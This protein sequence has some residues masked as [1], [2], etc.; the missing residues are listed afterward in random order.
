MNDAFSGLLE[1]FTFKSFWLE[2]LDYDGTNFVRMMQPWHDHVYNQKTIAIQFFALLLALIGLLLGAVKNRSLALVTLLIILT[3]VVFLVGSLPIPLFSQIFRS[4]FTKWSLP[5]ALGVSLCVA[6]LFLTLSFIRGR[7]GNLVSYSTLVAVIVIN[8]LIV[9]PVFNGKLIYEALSVSVPERYY[10]MFRKIN[11]LPEGTR[12]VSF[13][14]YSHWGWSFKDWGYRGSSLLTYG[15]KHSLMDRTFDVW[16]KTGEEYYDRISKSLY[17]NDIEAFRLTLNYYNVNAIIVDESVIVPGQV[18]QGVLEVERINTFLSELGNLYWN[19]A[20][21]G[22]KVYTIE[23]NHRD[24]FFKFDSVSLNQEDANYQSRLAE[25]SKHPF[26]ELLLPNKIELQKSKINKEVY[27]GKKSSID[28]EL[29][30]PPVESKIKLSGEIVYSNTDLTIKFEN[31]AKVS[32]NKNTVEVKADSIYLKGDFNK[33]RL[34]V[35]LNGEIYYLKKDSPSKVGVLHKPGDKMLIEIYSI[36]NQKKRVFAE[37][38]AKDFSKCWVRD[39][40]LGEIDVREEG[41]LVSI[42]TRDAAACTSIKIGKTEFVKSVA[43]LSLEY[44]PVI[45]GSRPS[46]CLL[47]EGGSECLH[48]DIFYSGVS[49]TLG[50]SSVER[51]VLFE[52]DTTYWLVVT[53][54]PSDVEGK[55]SAIKYSKP[56]LS[57]Y[58]LVYSFVVQGFDKDLLYEKRLAIES[59]QELQVNLPFSPVGLGVENSVEV[60]NCDSLKRGS[61]E[62]N[63]FENNVLIKA[64]GYG[65]LC[66]TRITPN[67]TNNSEG[68]LEIY[69]KNISGR[70]LKVF[71]FNQTSKRTDREFLLHRGGEMGETYSIGSW[72]NLN[73]SAYAITLENRAFGGVD[74]E[75]VFYGMNYVYAPLEWLSSIYVVNNQVQKTGEGGGITKVSQLMP[76]IFSID[77]YGSFDLHSNFGKDG[78]WL[79][80]Q[81]F[82][83]VP[84]ANTDSW[85]NSWFLE[86]CGFDGC[87]IQFVYLPQL[88][89][90]VIYLGSVGCLVFLLT[91]SKTRSKQKN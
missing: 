23:S 62:A 2:Y 58:P 14:S 28:G 73:E 81:N 67:L 70:P 51:S 69:S 55:D 57:E 63:S 65:S 90:Y 36:D 26:S 24:S 46:F 91:Y 42:N 59:G 29:I 25:R 13:P 86:D 32:A 79:G 68:F 40:L 54:R 11:E 89:Q 33:D 80:L 31:L 83:L 8:S 35:G 1:I 82:R 10:E 64:S 7:L 4:P 37:F 6:Q 53:A 34:A 76:A 88:I 78:L 71:V 50:K 18:D 19:S 16:N 39:G 44:E 15:I 22:L 21:N 61:V 12:V 20:D 72:D 75:N 17:N 43:N 66:F 60:K 48:D 45:D 9:Y 74:A 56:V 49:D 38:N 77:Y 85:T 41:G 3:S 52:K 30:I 47:V 87:N 5:L 27:F 84:Q